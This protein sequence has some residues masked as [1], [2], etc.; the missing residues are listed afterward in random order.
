MINRHEITREQAFYA[1]ENGEFDEDV[2]SY[3]YVI[4]IMTQDWCPQLY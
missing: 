2:L 4:V 1:I 3:E